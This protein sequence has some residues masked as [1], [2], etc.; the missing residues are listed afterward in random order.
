M[1]PRNPQAIATRFALALLAL[2]TVASACGIA[3]R[4]A[5]AGPVWAGELNAVP[6]ASR[7]VRTPGGLGPNA[8]P[9][10]FGPGKVSTFCNV[11]MKVT[12]IGIVGN[13]FTNTSSDP[14]A[15]WPGA[16]GVEYLFFAG[17]WAGAVDPAE[18][19]P[20]LKRRVSQTTEWRPP[21]LD[22]KDRIYVTYDGVP[23]GQRLVD[24]DNDGKIDEDPLDGYDND[25]DGKIDEDY[26]AISQ[27]E[28][29]CLMRDDTQEA[30]NTP[31]TEKH[32]PRGLQLR[33]NVYAFSVPGANDFVSVEWELTNVSGHELDSVY[34]GVRIDQDVGPVIRDRYFSDDLPEP[35]VPQ[36]PD[37]TISGN[38]DDP[39]NP[40]YPYI[41]TRNKTGNLHINDVE[42]Q[43]GRCDRDT[44]YINGFSMIDDD[45]DQ[46]QTPGA[47]TC[48]L[49]GHTIDPTGQKAPRRVGFNM[50]MFFQ[51]GTPYSQGGVPQ[52]DAERYDAMSRPRNIDPATGL[53]TQLPPDGNEINDYSSVFSVGPFLHMQPNESV[54]MQWA[55]AVAQIDYTTPRDNLKKRY[56]KMI[57]N[58]V[59]A[60]LTYRGSYEIRQG[61]DVPGPEDFGRETC[62][63]KVPGGPTQFA[64]CQDP[65]G[66][67]RPLLDNQCTWFDLDCN[68]CTGVPGYVLKR[69]T[70][71]APPPNPD[72]KLEPHDRSVTLQWDNKSEAT[73]DPVQGDFDFKGYKI[74]KA[75]NWT[76]PVG[77]SGPGD[78][79]WSLLATYFYYDAALNPLIVRDSTGALDTLKQNLFLN[80]ETGQIIYPNDIPC[81]EKEGQPG[82]CDVAQAKKFAFTAAGRDTT[83]DPYFV[84]RYPVGRYTYVDNNVLNGF[85]YFYSVT[86]FD[87]TGRGALV[88]EQEGRQAAVEGEGVVPQNAF[89]SSGPSANGGKPYVVPNPYRGRAD[90]DLTPNATDPTGTHV[91]FF[92]LPAD[93]TQVRIYTVSGDLVQILRPTDAQTNGHPQRESP[94]DSQASWNLISRNGQDVVSGIYIFSVESQGGKTTQGKFTVIR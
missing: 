78:D 79:L 17:I 59:N 53:I 30:I 6:D 41:R 86:A 76:R 57:T 49:L 8:V 18:T 81:Q 40:N 26:G 94:T 63:K 69:W 32:V 9:E 45:G 65:E 60:Q 74:W 50:Y 20:S 12:N 90:W 36:G 19:D 77:S 22:E 29:T 25:G 31:A 44:V 88:A 54:S 62:L 10:I 33:Q 37:P 23:G 67:F 16:S 82:V 61:I 35:R 28:F 7:G 3:P 11:W 13:P 68:Y 91:D 93:W 2:V 58:A 92:N 55:L 52:N 64:D 1:S 51:P 38:P 66:T 34:V 71:S 83:I 72:L 5:H 39:D 80:R 87:S 27:Q 24:D 56:P 4:A 15:Q 42:N 73:P 21:T 85:L 75:A 48:L 14:S 70:A 89:A 43:A 47:S 46:G 84:T